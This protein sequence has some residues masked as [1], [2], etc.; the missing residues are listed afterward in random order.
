MKPKEVIK[1]WKFGDDEQ[2]P[3]PTI[4]VN[5]SSSERRI[6]IRPK[7]DTGFD[8]S[9]A[10]DNE[11]VRKLHLAAKGTILIRTATGHSEAP[12]YTVNLHQVELGIDYTTLAIGA[13]RS[14]VGRRLLKDR[15]WLLDFRKQ[16]FCLIATH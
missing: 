9:L 10:I 7:V 4:E 2:P 12:I 15:E 5:L 16:R 11:V 3:Y 6:R 8:G 13:Q 14:L 1:C